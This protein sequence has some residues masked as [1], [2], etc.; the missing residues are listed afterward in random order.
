MYIDTNMTCTS[1]QR[2]EEERARKEREER[3]L[4]EQR[5]RALELEYEQERDRIEQEVELKSVLKQQMNELN[6]REEEVKYL[7]FQHFIITLLLK[8]PFDCKVYASFSTEPYFRTSSKSHAVAL[9]CNTVRS[10]LQLECSQ[11]I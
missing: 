2:E 8:C 1:I 9:C 4:E 7:I 6:E 3:E 10:A 11:Y 5:Q